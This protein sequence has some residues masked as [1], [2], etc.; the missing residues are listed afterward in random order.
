MRIETLT[1]LDFY[2]RPNTGPLK[3]PERFGVR[4][5]PY[6]APHGESNQH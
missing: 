2:A 3:N 1:I 5:K 4:Q 6:I